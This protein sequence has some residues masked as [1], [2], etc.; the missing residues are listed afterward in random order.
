MRLKEFLSINFKNRIEAAEKTGIDYYSLG[1]IA[2][3]NPE[4]LELA[5]GRFIL[6]HSNNVIIDLSVNI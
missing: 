1:N 2:K 4:V 5:D 6:K 3:R